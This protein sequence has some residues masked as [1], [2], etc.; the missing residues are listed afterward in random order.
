MYSILAWMFQD[1]DWDQDSLVSLEDWTSLVEMSSFVLG[2]WDW[3]LRRSPKD[4]LLTPTMKADGAVRE[5]FQ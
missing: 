1:A 3:R 2:H 5:G 4:S